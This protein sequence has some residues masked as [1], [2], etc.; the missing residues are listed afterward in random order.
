M[1]VVKHLDAL[2]L[3]LLGVDDAQRA[4]I[5]TLY[6]VAHDGSTGLVDVVG[7]ADDDDA[8]WV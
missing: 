6:E 8:P 4:H 1:H 2:H 3:V 5:A 7:A